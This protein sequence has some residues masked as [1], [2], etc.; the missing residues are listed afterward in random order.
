MACKD[1]D[2]W[3]EFSFYLR[4][5]DYVLLDDEQV[6]WFKERGY[7]LER[8]IEVCDCGY[9]ESCLIKDVSVEDNLKLIQMEELFNSLSDA[10]KTLWNAKH[11]PMPTA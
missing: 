10:G 4:E 11:N 8:Y 9:C 5:S 1:E 7:V 3:G 2:E 6:K